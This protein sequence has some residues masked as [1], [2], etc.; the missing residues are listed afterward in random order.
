[1]HGG[2]FYWLRA[3]TAAPIEVVA[4]LKLGRIRIYRAGLIL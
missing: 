4:D 3:V 1:L 2:A